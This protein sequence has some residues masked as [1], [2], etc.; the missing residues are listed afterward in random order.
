LQFP[1]FDF[2][3]K[4][5]SF[6]DNLLLLCAPPKPKPT[7]VAA[8]AAAA[9]AAGGADA[10]AGEASEAGAVPFRPVHACPVDMFPHTP[11]CELVV[12]LER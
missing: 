10:D 3:V 4:N 7:P 11:H 12:A 6:L 8:A 1:R 9:A 2:R 5:G